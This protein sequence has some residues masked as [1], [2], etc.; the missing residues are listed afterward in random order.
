MEFSGIFWSFLV[1]GEYNIKT[2]AIKFSLIFLLHCYNQ[3]AKFVTKIFNFFCSLQKSLRSIETRKLHVKIVVFKLQNSI[4]RV[5]RRVV[6]LVHCVVA[7]VPISSQNH[8]MLWIIILPR[9]TA[10]Q[11]LIL[12]SSVNFVMQNF[13]ALMLYVNTKT[14]KMVHKL[15][16]DRAILMWRT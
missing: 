8:K 9:S 16:S 2:L 13:L 10:P 6:L 11:N 5:T 12:I 3:V 7:N 1:N 15:D 14:P 4:F